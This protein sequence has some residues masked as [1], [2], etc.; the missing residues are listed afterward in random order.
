LARA[1]E[2]S[3]GAVAVDYCICAGASGRFKTGIAG[4]RHRDRRNLIFETDYNGGYETGRKILEMKERPTAIFAF[5]DIIAID[6][7][8]AIEESGLKIPRDISI[9][10]FDDI[11][12]ASRVY[13]R[14][15]TMRIPKEEMGRLALKRLYETAG[16]RDS[17]PMQVVLPV[18]LVE[19]ETV[20]KI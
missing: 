17:M 1:Q 6:I 16:G 14:L 19:R 10:G 8:R 13:P 4:S 7:K 15:T 5:T 2:N 9:M 11:D 20:R 12:A 3:A 18:N